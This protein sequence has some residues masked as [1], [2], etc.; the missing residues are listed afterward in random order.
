MYENYVGYVHLQGKAPYGKVPLWSLL[1][2]L[3]NAE[4]AQGKQ[5]KTKAV[6]SVNVQPE[7]LPRS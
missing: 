2:R 5:K 3:R 4:T 1:Q 7:R 6:H